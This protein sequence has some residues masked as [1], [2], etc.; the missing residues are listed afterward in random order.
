[1]KICLEIRCV[2]VPSFSDV[3]AQHIAAPGGKLGP[4]QNACATVHLC[5]FETAAKWKLRW[6]CSLFSEDFKGCTYTGRW[7][8]AL[9]LLSPPRLDSGY[10]VYDFS[11]PLTAAYDNLA[12][13]SMHH[14]HPQINNANDHSPSVPLITLPPR[15]NTKRVNNKRPNSLQGSSHRNIWFLSYRSPTGA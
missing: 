5:P 15:M 11:R 7:G 12:L 9:S 1:M 2:P 13:H 6:F 10:D 8:L 4:W 14:C 3:A